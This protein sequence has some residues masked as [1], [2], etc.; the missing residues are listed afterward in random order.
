M[1]NSWQ[2]SVPTLLIWAPVISLY[3]QTQALSLPAMGTF[4]HPQTQNAWPELSHRLYPSI[5]ALHSGFN[6]CILNSFQRLWIFWGI[7]DAKSGYWPRS[8]VPSQV[9]TVTAHWAGLPL[10][11]SLQAALWLVE[12]PSVQLRQ[13]HS[14]AQAAR[15]KITAH[16]YKAWCCLKIGAL[17]LFRN[18][19]LI[20]EV[21][22]TTNYA[23]HGFMKMLSTYVH[24]LAFAELT[25]LH[26]LLQTV[27]IHNV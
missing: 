12:P 10:V 20:S 21:K 27:N 24:L 3:C 6:V 15:A 13:L 8:K 11:E 4:S 1:I 25:C 23:F 19:I 26:L 22:P 18:L 16:L 7:A 2:C 17:G 9:P 14:E 5:F